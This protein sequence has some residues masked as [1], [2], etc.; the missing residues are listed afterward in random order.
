MKTLG[1][2]ARSYLLDGERAFLVSGE[3]HYFRVPR[4][5]WETRLSLFVAS[6]GNCVA[7]YVPWILHE[8][9]EG[10]IRFGDVPERDLEGFLTLCG[11]MGLQVVCRPG[12]YQYSELKYDGLP[13][14]LCDGYPEVL[15]RNSKGEVFRGSSVSYLHPTFLEKVKRW[16]AVVCPI[17]ARH[18][19]SRGGPVSMVQIDNELMGIHEWFGRWDYNR[20]TMGF[21]RE[22]GRLAAFLRQRYGRVEA[23]NAAWGIAVEAFGKVDPTRL[24]DAPDIAAAADTAAD[25]NAAADDDASVAADTGTN[26]NTNGTLRTLAHIRR[27]TDYR[28]FYFGTIAAYVQLLFQ[29]MRTEGIDCQ[30]VHNSANPNMNA[31]FLETVRLLGS[32]FLLGSDHYYNLDQE[33]SQNNPTPQYAVNVYYSNEMLRLMGYPATIFELPGGSLSDWPPVTPEDL[34]C[35]YL[36]N[37]ALGMKGSNYYIFTGGPN[38]AGVSHHGDV[39]DYGASI[40]ANG[41]IRPTYDAQCTFGRFLSE[42]AWLAGAERDAD[43]LVGLDWE[44]ARNRTD[45][46]KGAGL[47]FS[48]AGAWRF[49]RKGL[50][51]TAFCASLGGNLVDLSTLSPHDP[52]VDPRPLVVATSACMPRQVQQALAAHAARGGKLLLAPVLPHLDE[53]HQPCTLLRDFLGAGGSRPFKKTSPVLHVGPVRN[54]LVTGSLWTLDARPEQAHTIASEETTGTELGWKLDMPGGGTVIWLG[55]QWMHAKHEHTAML[56]HLLSELGLE[57]PAVLCDNPNVWTSLRT[58]GSR[59]MLFVMNLLSAGMQAQVSV[60]LPDGSYRALEPLALKPMEVR[61]LAI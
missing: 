12:P 18:M 9:T 27:R 60:R 36:T 1:W 38:P 31:Y 59:G 5:D 11:R 13:G 46:D 61:A 51:T 2:D 33:W 57:S 35:C 10:D 22:D 17:L 58:D 56:R 42:Q 7:T 40:G 26:T 52:Q 14:W 37:T 19:A 45:E 15:A 50:L 53:F 20:D 39:Y 44:Q 29:W 28:D 21:G 4:Q 47:G 32:D 3:F 30:I 55:V 8:P 43:F 6:G 24:T 41:E 23:L 48:Q 34:L 25:S 16:Y 49:L 54:I